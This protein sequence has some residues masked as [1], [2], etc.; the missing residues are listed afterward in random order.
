MGGSKPGHFSEPEGA[1]DLP[2][3]PV[4]QGSSALRNPSLKISV[5][6]QRC[7]KPQKCSSRSARGAHLEM[8]LL[9]SWVYVQSDISVGIFKAQ[10]MS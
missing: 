4:I 8:E 9:R 5:S 2:V 6:A 7:L 10:L 3:D 1:L